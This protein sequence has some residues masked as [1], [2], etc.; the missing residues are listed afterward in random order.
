MMQYPMLFYMW[1]TLYQLLY[2]ILAF[3]TN[4]YSPYGDLLISLTLR[5]VKLGHWDEEVRGLAAKAVGKL[6]SLNPRRSVDY[7]K[8][9]ITLVN[10]ILGPL[11]CT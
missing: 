5:C 10:V 3:K 7:N 11:H 2:Q 4:A 6:V 1:G 8:K 9:Q